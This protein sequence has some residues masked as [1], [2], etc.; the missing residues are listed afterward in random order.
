VKTESQKRERE[1]EELGIKK[2]KKRE[3]KHRVST[4]TKWG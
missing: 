4:F 1:R 2:R 3:L